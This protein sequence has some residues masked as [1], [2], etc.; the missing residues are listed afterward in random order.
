MPHQR[1]IAAGC[2]MLRWSCV[3]LIGVFFALSFLAQAHAEEDPQAVELEIPLPE[4]VGDN[5]DFAGGV[6]LDDSR[7]NE[8]PPLPPPYASVE[9]GAYI[10][11]WENYRTLI[12]IENTVGLV[13]GCWIVTL[14]TKAEKVEVERGH[15]IPVARG[16][17]VVAY[18]G[19]M[20]A[21]KNGIIHANAQH[22]IL[23]GLLLD[24]WSPDSFSIAPDKSVSTQDDD[25]RHP[26]NQGVVEKQVSA[27]DNPAEYRK[28]LYVAQSIVN[29]TL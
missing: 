12:A 19:S 18:R 21:D 1:F 16:Q 20:Y 23:T 29:G 11:N 27:H 10:I 22:A 25:P 9:A 2:A 17:V 15:F 13:N 4:I 5:F 3:F 8:R 7:S 24:H 26:T 6:L 14:A 28:L